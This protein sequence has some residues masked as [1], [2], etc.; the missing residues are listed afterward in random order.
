LACN[1][2]IC[3]CLPSVP[4][5]HMEEEATVVIKALTSECTTF[6]KIPWKARL[7]RLFVIF[8]FYKTW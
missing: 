6:G 5:Q 8:N 4:W 7:M 2:R 3:I 1:D